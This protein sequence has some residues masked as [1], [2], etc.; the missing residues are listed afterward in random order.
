MQRGD[1]VG[2]IDEDKSHPTRGGNIQVMNQEGRVWWMF[3]DLE[4][5]L[6]VR[7][8]KMRRS[9]VVRFRNT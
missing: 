7:K 3:R 9:S 1:V 6:F 2:V 8:P 5:T 4:G